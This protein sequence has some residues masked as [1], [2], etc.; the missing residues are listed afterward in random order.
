[1][2]LENKVLLAK[3]ITL[4]YRENVLAT[5][6]DSSADLVRTALK[7]VTTSDN[8][9]GLNIEKNIV[10]GLK[11]ISLEMCDNIKED[12]EL[13]TLIEQI[14]VTCEND[15]GLFKA[16]RDALNNEFSDSSL[17][18]SIVIL[19]RQLDTHFREK[20]IRDA[21][22]TASLKINFKRDEI[23]DLEQY[24]TEFWAQVEPLTMVKR[25]KDPAIMNQLELG[26]SDEVR[27]TFRQLVQRGADT[28]IYKTMWNGFNE[29]SQGGLRVQTSMHQGL[30]H[31]YKSGVNM[32][33]FSQ[34]LRAN[35]PFTVEQNKIPCM[36]RISFED[37]TDNIVRFMYMQMKYSET[38]EKV[39]VDGIDPDEVLAYVTER[40]QKRGWKV[41]LLRVNPTEWTYKDVFNYIVSL[42][43]EGYAIEGLWIDYLALMPTV[44]CVQGFAGE[45]LK[46]LVR[47]FRN[48]CMAKGIL[49]VTPHQMS[50]DAKTLLRGQS[51]DATFVKDV[52]MRGYSA[53]AKGLDNELDFEFYHHIAKHGK[54]A[55]LTW[56]RGK[57]RL[58]TII[59]DSQKFFVLKFPDNKMP[60][61]DDFPDEA[62]MRRIGVSN[63]ETAE[64]QQL[65]EF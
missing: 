50:P 52:A 45:A 9:F 49:F 32:T 38:R 27:D 44:G 30:S 15:E 55:Y 40:L 33:L 62:V 23:K 20:A 22:Q 43:A 19:R 18:K 16:L 59:D 6:E 47:R 58:P 60:I 48:F 36:V 28:R 41:F 35:D 29:M 4:L 54:Q 46:D 37:E 39:D 7:D 64:D 42:E 21:F 26:N 24:V 10:S 65:L 57:H 34:V 53:G 11:G 25:A 63:A 17:R 14:R 13:K 51:T 3:C 2:L 1:M 12:I 8:T 31:N 61:P 56:H 5:Y